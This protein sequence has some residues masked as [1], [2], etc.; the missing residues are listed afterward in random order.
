[1]LEKKRKKQKQQKKQIRG[2]EIR[3]F[4]YTAFYN[5]KPPFFIENDAFTTRPRGSRSRSAVQAV[6][7]FRGQKR[8]GSGTRRTFSGSCLEISNQN[9]TVVV[10]GAPKPLIPSGV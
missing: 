10:Q 8:D 4:G 6:S 1:M 5:T 3:V 9:C 7:P 2:T